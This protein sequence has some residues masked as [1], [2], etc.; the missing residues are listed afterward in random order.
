MARSKT[1]NKTLA[2]GEKVHAR[3][4]ELQDRLGFKNHDETV[5]YLLTAVTGLPPQQNQ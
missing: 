2:V 4:K 1:K 3:V 5:N